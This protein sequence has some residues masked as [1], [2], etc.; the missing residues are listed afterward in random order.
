MSDWESIE[1]E[2]HDWQSPASAVWAKAAYERA[3]RAARA[4][5]FAAAVEQSENVLRGRANLWR[6]DSGPYKVLRDAAELV[7]AMQDERADVTQRKDPKP[8]VC[9]CDDCVPR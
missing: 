2:V 9:E 1:D 3:V 8:H 4:E 5:G 6:S 7:R